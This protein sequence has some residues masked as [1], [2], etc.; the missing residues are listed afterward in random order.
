MSDYLYNL[1]LGIFRVL[2]IF[3]LMFVLMPRKI[4][5]DEK[6]NQLSD[7]FLA[8]IILV[9]AFSIVLISLLIMAN[10]YDTISLLLGILL[11]NGVVFLIKNNGKVSEI[12]LRFNSFMLIKLESNFKL[13]LV[14]N[15][16]V[17]KIQNRFYR[18]SNNNCIGNVLLFILLLITSFLRLKPVFVTAAPFSIEAYNTLEYV[19]HLQ[20]NNL[21]HDGSIVL[22][23]LHSV[24]DLFFQ[25][26]R[27]DPEILVHIFGALSAVLLTYVIFYVVNRNTGNSV[28]GLIAGSIFG[29]FSAVLPLNIQQQVE[30]NSTI[31]GAIFAVAGLVLMVNFLN[32]K[33]KKMAYAATAG[34][35]ASLLTNTF[36]AGMLVMA[37]IPMLIA[38]L[39]N[40]NRQL[41][42]KKLYWLIVSLPFLL[43]G[44]YYGLGR[45][46]TGKIIL[47]ESIKSF[48]TG[49][50]FS[51][52]VSQD[53]FFQTET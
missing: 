46:L 6:S 41:R 42:S 52:F 9:G 30:A 4:F 48:F 39:V 50:S 44:V 22:K 45:F 10:I 33:N 1:I 20:I 26:S 31:L 12:F 43:M 47:I 15:L 11:I 32:N 14:N 51:R 16:R 40:N 36:F 17:G 24:L 3:Y 35:G 5:D 18:A 2:V 29:I 21:F 19:K 49:N 23:G 37:T 13:A 8:N 38:Y 53:Y 34:I 7:D 28:A 27:T 25:F